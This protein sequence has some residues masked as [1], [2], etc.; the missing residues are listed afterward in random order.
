MKQSRS[1]KG[2]PF[3]VS[4]TDDGAPDD[5]DDEEEEEDDEE[6]EDELVGDDEGSSSLSVN[7]GS[8]RLKFSQSAQNRRQQ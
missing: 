8:S 1:L 3:A 5:D 2:V 7:S 6:E 4:L